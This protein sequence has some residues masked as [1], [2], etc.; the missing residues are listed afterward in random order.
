MKDSAVLQE[1]QCPLCLT[2]IDFEGDVFTMNNNTLTCTPT[3]PNCHKTFSY[4]I[5]VHWKKPK[6]R[7]TGD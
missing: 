3:C 5:Y 2:F 7:I 4:S 6:K 1:I